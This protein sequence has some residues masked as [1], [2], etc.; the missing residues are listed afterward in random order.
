MGHLLHEANLLAAAGLTVMPVSL[1]L[2]PAE[3]DLRISS[4]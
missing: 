1:P 3:V 4:G 2:K